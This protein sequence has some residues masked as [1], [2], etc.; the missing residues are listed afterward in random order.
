MSI[1]STVAVAY[2]PGLRSADTPSAIRFVTTFVAKRLTVSR[3]AAAPN[4]FR[5]RINS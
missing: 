2:I 5:I 3:E 4:L 1:L